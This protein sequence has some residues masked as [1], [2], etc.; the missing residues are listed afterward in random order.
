MTAD[1]VAVASAAWAAFRSPDPRPLLS[2]AASR[3]LPFLRPA[4][5]RLL[6]EYPSTANGL[7]GTEE[8]ALELLEV[9]EA[10]GAALFSASQA[11]EAAPFIG[12][13]TFFAMLRRLAAARVPL[14][15]VEANFDA[16]DLRDARIAITDAGREVLAARADHVRL[17][18][19][20]VWR[21]GVHLTGSHCS[22]WR[23]DARAERLVS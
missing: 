7:S 22:P 21:G 13:T 15:T 8:L 11:R 17:N 20:D 14:V 23:W 3:L 10:S 18:G 6:A 5:R 2:I 16:V 4:V 1:H 19:I 12:D 9:G